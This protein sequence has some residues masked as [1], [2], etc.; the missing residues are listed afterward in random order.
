MLPIALTMNVVLALLGGYALVLNAAVCPPASFPSPPPMSPPFN[1]THVTNAWVECNNTRP[2][3]PTT[4]ACNKT[5]ITSADWQVCERLC[6]EDARCYSWAWAAN[7]H[8]C[9]TRSDCYWPAR[10]GTRGVGSW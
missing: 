3:D 2:G 6:A 5:N 4:G 9:Y 7:N 1:D 10:T 8:M